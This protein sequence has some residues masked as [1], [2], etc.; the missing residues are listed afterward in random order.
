M[1]SFTQAELDA[2]FSKVANPDDWKAPV[3]AIVPV[4]ELAVTLVAISHFTATSA[5]VRIATGEDLRADGRIVGTS[6]ESFEVTAP[7]YRAGPAGP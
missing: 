7:G 6:I 1:I 5:T 2:A 4:A 3:K